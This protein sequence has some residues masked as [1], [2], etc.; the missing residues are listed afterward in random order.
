[1]WSLA[2]SRNHLR[3]EHIEAPRAT[4]GHVT[5]ARDRSSLTARCRAAA[6]LPRGWFGEPECYDG[7]VHYRDE[8]LNAHSRPT[9]FAFLSSRNPMNRLCLRCRS[10]VHSTYSN[11]P[12]STGFS[13]RHS[14]I[15]AAVNP[16]PQRPAFFSGKFANGHSLTCSGLIF[17]NN[18]TRDAGV[19][20]LRVRAAYVS[21]SPS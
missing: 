4:P 9:S 16:A 2:A 14:A 11:C 18:S 8:P 15:F 5:P 7:A 3:V 10:P 1:M 6:A 13:H 21:L 20:P 19:N 17:L 12:T